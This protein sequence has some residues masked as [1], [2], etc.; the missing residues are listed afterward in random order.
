GEQRPETPDP[1]PLAA[2][3]SRMHAKDELRFPDLSLS[4]VKLLGRG[5]SRLDL[6][7]KDP[8]LHFGLAVHDSSH[9]T[10][11]NRRYADRLQQRM[12][13]A[14]LA[15]QPAPY[16]NDELA[17]LASHATEMVDAAQ[18]VERQ[19]RKVIAAG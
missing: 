7:G 18:K 13:K 11:P 17:A 19:M 14:V 15:G 3:L 4:I 5:E 12:L 2:F 10:A 16:T 9:T 1:P 6:P 8:G